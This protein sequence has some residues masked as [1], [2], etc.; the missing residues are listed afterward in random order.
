MKENQGKG[1]LSGECREYDIVDDGT[2]VIDCLHRQ[3]V[4]KSQASTST[5]QQKHLPS[6]PPLPVPVAR[7]GIPVCV[8]GRVSERHKTR[9][10]VVDNITKCTSSNDEPK[11]WLEVH[12]L[13]KEHY[14]SETPFQIPQNPTLV[15]PQ[16][17]SPLKV[18]SINTAATAT[19]I[20]NTP[21]TICSTPSTS[22]SSPITV[23]SAASSPTKS[24]TQSPQKLRHPSR[25]HSRDLTGNTFRIYIKHYMD[26]TAL[27]SMALPPSE[28]SDNESSLSESEYP[29]TPTKRRHLPDD[30][31]T[32]RPGPSGLSARTPRPRTRIPPLSFDGYHKPVSKHL[33]NPPQ[34]VKTAMAGFTLSHLRRVPELADMAVRVVKAVAKRRQRE[35]RK[36]A[37]DALA[38]AGNS[39]SARPKSS[40]SA[41]KSTL[42]DADAEKLSPRVKRLFQATV[43]QLLREGSIVLWDGPVLACPV[44][45]AQGA[46]ETS[47]LWKANITST[48]ADSTVFSNASG[49]SL[50]EEQMAELSDPDDGEEAYMPLSPRFLAGVVEEALGRL[51]RVSKGRVY[52]GSTKEGILAYLRRDDRWRY[53]SEWNVAEALEVL[54]TEGRVWCVGKDRW[55]LSI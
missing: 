47:G 53:V 25:L 31:E 51:A 12:R 23:S 50:D 20:P 33:P 29:T 15:P 38:A 16:P 26:R 37:K 18:P 10:I 43:V 24:T 40:T 32:P 17:A 45:P 39:S 3:S 4:K 28:D 35:E 42:V 13:H 22:R 6:L 9:E 46:G 7:V 8:V 5:L 44:R 34:N 21:S 55:D 19:V 52:G 2:A 11:H 49:V 14:S 36:K 41:L 48:S 27:G 54:R 1:K 30:S